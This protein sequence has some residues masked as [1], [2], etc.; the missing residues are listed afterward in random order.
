MELLTLF[1]YYIIRPKE[2]ILIYETVYNNRNG[3][4][5]QITIDF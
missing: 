3:P 1:N 5:N 2:L 4:I